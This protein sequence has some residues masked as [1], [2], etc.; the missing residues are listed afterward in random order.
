MKEPP[1]DHDLRPTAR[2]QVER[3][4]VLEHAHRIVG[5]EHRDGAGQPDPLGTGRDG[6]QH[7]RRRGD[8]ELGAVVLADAVPSHGEGSDWVLVLE[9]Q[10]GD[11]R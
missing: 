8:G 4:E 11:R 1:P 2:Q 5:A 6:S 3:R 9:S 7:H 10:G